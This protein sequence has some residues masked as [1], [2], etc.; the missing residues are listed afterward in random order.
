MNLKVRHL[1]GK[2]W[3]VIEYDA[4]YD[5]DPSE[6]TSGGLTES[7][8]NEIVL[9]QGGLADCE[10]YVRLKESDLLE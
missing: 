10:A 9:Y 7:R 3:Q 1:L 4:E 8:T 2:T 5:Y 6:V